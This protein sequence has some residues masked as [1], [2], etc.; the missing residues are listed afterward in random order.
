MSQEDERVHLRGRPCGLAEGQPGS[1][2]HWA[3]TGQALRVQGGGC[4]LPPCLMGPEGQGSKARCCP[5]TL[6]LKRK[7]DS[8]PST[9]YPPHP[10]AA[11]HPLSHRRD[12]ASD[13]REVAG[14]PRGP[15]C[16]RV[17]GRSQVFWLPGQLSH[18]PHLQDGGRE[19]TGEVAVPV[20]PA[21]SSCPCR[22]H[23][24][25]L[26][27]GPRLASPPLSTLPAGPLR[28]CL[29]FSPSRLDRPSLPLT[30]ARR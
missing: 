21:S 12:G 5:L 26:S 30:F 22:S 29:R 18:L 16:G 15:V 11:S 17:P 28:S 25:R 27:L 3:L 23:P 20:N 14:W 19:G 6:E 2:P 1:G 10:S 8:S 4:S 9:P 24:G 7:F 13:P